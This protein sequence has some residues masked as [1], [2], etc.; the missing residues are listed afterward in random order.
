M[1]LEQSQQV[2]LVQAELLGKQIAPGSKHGHTLGTGLMQAVGLGGQAQV[3]SLADH[4]HL[5]PA[6]LEHRQQ[7]G[8]QSGLAAACGTADSQH[9]RMLEAQFGGKR[10]FLFTVQKYHPPFYPI[11]KNCRF[12]PQCAQSAAAL[13]RPAPRSRTTWRQDAPKAR[14]P[15]TGRGTPPFPLWSRCGGP[16]PALRIRC[17]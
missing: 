8:Q 14:V 5:Q 15:R 4:A 2:L 11:G 7:R 17:P 6:A 9:C 3:V 10:L 1:A 13:C 16:C 12:T